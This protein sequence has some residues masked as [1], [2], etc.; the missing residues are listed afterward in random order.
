MFYFFQVSNLSLQLLDPVFI[1][2]ASLQN[3]SQSV[4]YN[5]PSS[6]TNT[7]MNL[8]NMFSLLIGAADTIDGFWRNVMDVHNRR[9][10]LR[11][12]DLG[13]ILHDSSGSRH[14]NQSSLVRFQQVHNCPGFFQSTL[15]PGNQ[16]VLSQ[17]YFAFDS[18]KSSS[19]G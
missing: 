2:L 17:G 7:K 15:L 9:I 13:Y 18:S 5:A 19:G 11:K 16:V 10:H 12:I 8:R 14:K 1:I 4:G 6:L 3:V